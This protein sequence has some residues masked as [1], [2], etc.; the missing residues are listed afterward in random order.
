MVEYEE[1]P[2]IDPQT[3]QATAPPVPPPDIIEKESPPIGPEHELSA[4]PKKPSNFLGML[5]NVVLFAVLFALGVG[6]SVFLRQYLA[7]LSEGGAT[8]QTAQITVVPTPLITQSA[9]PYANWKTYQP[10][11]GLTKQ[12]V[13]G[14]T[15]KLPPDILTPICDGPTCASQGTYLP[16]GTRLTIAPR[17]KGQALPTTVGAIMTDAGGREFIMKEASISG[18]PSQEFTGLFA[19]TTGGGYTF[20]QIRG[21]VVHGPEG[22]SLEVNHFTPTG[23]NANW[24]TDDGLFDKIVGT[25]VFKRTI[26]PTQVVTPAAS[27]TATLTQ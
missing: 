24:D 3:G 22:I 14:V 15:L 16:G 11:S 27:P 9:D 17:G 6:A 23:V 1:T 13:A 20:A 19:G 21:V 26:L 10:I 5:G 4:P 2:V 12:P 7:Q 8:T 18:L 25:I